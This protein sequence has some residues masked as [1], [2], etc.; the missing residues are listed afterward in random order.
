LIVRLHLIQSCHTYITK[1]CTIQY[2]LQYSPI[3]DAHHYL[4]C[5]I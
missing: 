2:I 3:P 5:V 4:F 1:H